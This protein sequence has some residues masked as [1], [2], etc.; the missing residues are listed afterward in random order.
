MALR[1]APMAAG[2]RQQASNMTP[3]R[4][5]AT[6]GS[7]NSSSRGAKLQKQ[8]HNK[9]CVS[10]PAFIVSP[11]TLRIDSARSPL[12]VNVHIS[13]P[14]PHCLCLLPSRLSRLAPPDSIPHLVPPP[15]P[16]PQRWTR[17]AFSEYPLLSP[18]AGPR[19]EHS[20]LRVAGSRGRFRADLRLPGPENSG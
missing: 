10:N 8:T 5:G 6:C 1:G 19:G 4:D 20:G 7:Q 18:L 11:T 15:Q 12:L 2:S 13:L 9:K 16:Q 14:T 17:G 3:T